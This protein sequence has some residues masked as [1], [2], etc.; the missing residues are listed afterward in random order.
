MVSDI[1]P[2]GSEHYE[3][4]SKM[5]EHQHQRELFSWAACVGRCGID[6][7]REWVL[8]DPET[9]KRPS[10]PDLIEEL[11]VEPKPDDRLVWLHAIPNGG[12]RGGNR[13]QRA[14]Q[15]SKMK[16]EGVKAGI[17]D[18]FLPYPSGRLH[19]L[20][21][22]LKRIKGNQN[23]KASPEQVAF[24][25]YVNR[26][27]Y[28]WVKVLGYTAAIEAIVRYFRCRSSYMGP[29]R[30]FDNQEVLRIDYHHIP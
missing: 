18:I 24:G 12:S 10:L 22:E 19:G 8:T 11:G 14:A 15:G 16:A 25:E 21:I 2:K 28:K 3:R 20:Y 23:V 13:S 5:T 17:A 7:A 6:I 29:V 9:L 1:F 27:G 4:Y 30:E 26:M